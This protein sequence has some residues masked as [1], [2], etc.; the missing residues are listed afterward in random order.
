MELLL[1]NMRHVQEIAAQAIH[2]RADSVR[3]LSQQNRLRICYNI[4]RCSLIYLSLFTL[5]Q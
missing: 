3:L 1:Y 2:R 4:V 5:D